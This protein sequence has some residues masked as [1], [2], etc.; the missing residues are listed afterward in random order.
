MS[1]SSYSHL[2]DSCDQFYSRGNN[3]KLAG[4]IY[5]H[6]ITDNRLGGLSNRNFRMFRHLCGD[7]TLSNVV[8]VTTMWDQI[9]RVRGEARELELMNKSLFFEPAIAHGAR[10]ARH[11]NTRESALSIVRSILSHRSGQSVLQ[12]QEELESGVDIHETKA[13][14]ELFKDLKD[15]SVRHK[16]ELREIIE[17]MQEAIRLRDEA[18]RKELNLERE[19]LEEMIKRVEQ[20]SASLVAGYADTLTRLEAKMQSSTR[21]TPARPPFPIV[22]PPIVAAAE[23]ESNAI[24]EGKIAA[25]FPIFGFWGRLAVMLAPFSL[26][27]K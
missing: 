23:T 26:S 16:N 4:V 8:I 22:S 27:W 19:K 25:A 13:G 24:L 14:Q 10:M 15:Q 3:I 21:S 17:E 5:M 18:S 2:N 6:R 11:D 9:E 12:I 20:E 1:Y 7:S